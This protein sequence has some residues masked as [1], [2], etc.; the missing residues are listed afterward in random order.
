MTDVSAHTKVK[1]GSERGFGL[2]F[3]FVFAVIA[4]WPLVFGQGGGLRIWA[5]IVAL[6]FLVAA[7][8]APQVLKPLNRIW[9]LFGL[10]LGKI[11]APIVMGIIFFV[12]VTPIGIIRRMFIP[13]PL[14]QTFRPEAESYWITR[15]P[16]QLA[17]SS[18][19]KQF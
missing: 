14:N 16:E 12:T 1:M 11:V 18:M 7:Y 9:F 17:S 19:R 13:D 8:A 2:V 5:L 10:L 4:F 6:V 3:A 15:D